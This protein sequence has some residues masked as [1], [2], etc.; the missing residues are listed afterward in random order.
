MKFRGFNFG[1]YWFVEDWVNSL[2]QVL[3]NI[4]Q[5]R[6][7]VFHSGAIPNERVEGIIDDTDEFQYWSMLNEILSQVDALLISKIL[8]HF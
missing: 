4:Y 6:N 2:V 7:S 3:L 1:K 5:L 8:N